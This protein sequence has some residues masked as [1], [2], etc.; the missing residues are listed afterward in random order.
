MKDDDM[1][2][3]FCPFEHPD[4]DEAYRIF[5]ALRVT[6]EEEY[7]GLSP[8][9]RILYDVVRFEAE[10][11]NG[12]IDQFFYN[13]SGNHAL[14][15]LEALEKIGATQS[16]EFLVAAFSLFPNGCPSKDCEKR[17]EELEGLRSAD[18]EL[19]LDDLVVGDIEFDLYGR[20]FAFRRQEAGAD[21]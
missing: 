10:V 11:M 2:A 13:E 21:Q 3:W 17:R 12:G 5:N 9:E 6:T 16:H 8:R 15:T 18:L 14:E 1:A 7:L 20:L 19:T 4:A